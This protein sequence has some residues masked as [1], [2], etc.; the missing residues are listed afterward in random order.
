MKITSDVS[1]LFP[2]HRSR[3]TVSASSSPFSDILTAVEKNA[4]D[5]RKPDFT[6]MTRQEL[7]DWVNEQIRTGKMT[8]EESCPFVGMTLKFCSAT[9]QPVDPA[10]DAE[11]V[12][13]IA[14]TCLGIEGA[15]A[16]H[17]IRGARQLESALEIM[18]RNQGGASA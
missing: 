14:K 11:R 3:T 12:D 17:D 6:R 5:S 2:E 13:F 18:L 15:L 10:T 4:S 8:F 16:R 7:R 1:S 9:G